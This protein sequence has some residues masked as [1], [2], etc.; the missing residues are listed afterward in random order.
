MKR[1]QMVTSFLFPL[2]EKETKRSSLGI[3]SGQLQSQIL[4]EKNS[5]KKPQTAFLFTD[6]SID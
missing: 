4:K 1:K 5:A 3:F 6:F 2:M